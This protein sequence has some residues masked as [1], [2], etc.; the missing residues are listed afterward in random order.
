[1]KQSIK[2]A[3]LVIAAMA[4][5]F[6]GCKREEVEGTVALRSLAIVNGG[7]A[8]TQRFEGAVDAENKTVV[9]TNVAAETAV[10]A[11]QF[12]CKASSGALLTQSTYN[13]LEGNAADAMELKKSIVIRNDRLGAEVEYSVVIKLAEPT[14][15]PIVSG[16]KFK[17]GNGDVVELKSTSIV[18]GY[19]L[20][21]VE[22]DEVE[23]VELVVRPARATVTYEN[24]NDNKIAKA[25]PGKALLNFMGMKA[26]YIFSFD[27]APPVGADFANAKVHAWNVNTNIYSDFTGGYTRA[28]DMDENYVLIVNGAMTG[29]APHPYLLR[30]DDLLNDNADNKID[31]SIEGIVENDVDVYNGEDLVTAKSTFYVSAGRLTQGH[32]YICNL[33]TADNQNLKVY[34]WASPTAK[35]EL[36]C[37]WD[38]TFDADNYWPLRTGDNMGL[39]L[40]ASGNGYAY[41]AGQETGTER[42]IRFTVENFSTFKDPVALA[43]PQPCQYY[44]ICNKVGLND[45]YV[46]TSVFST[47]LYLFD[48]DMTLLQKVTFDGMTDGANA[49]D[50]RVFEYNR[51]RYLMLT[52]ARRFKWYRPEALVIFDITEGMTT[53]EALKNLDENRPVDPNWEPDPDDPYD[54]PATLPFVQAYNYAFSSGEE[55]AVGECAAIC[56]VVEKDGKMLVFTAAPYAGMALIEF[57][58]A[59]K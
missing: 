5:V 41:F 16:V 46:F 49:T 26:E 9:F 11:I 28:A 43:L 14:E 4:V 58:K 19:I 31:L 8:G 38:G 56:S 54:E 24:I 37:D 39:A 18:D 10:E 27:A 13:F 21:G 33:R 42:I 20:L 48:H 25:N 35:P 15:Y 59:T 40:D 44:G 36:V 52:N 47:V 1:M 51:A 7:L 12:E 30:V 6:S 22:E 53:A 57:G 2:L 32:I 45:E 34:H 17:K 29:A 23:L 50:P 55:S 3:A